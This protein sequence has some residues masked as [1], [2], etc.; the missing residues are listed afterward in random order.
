MDDLHA[1]TVPSGPSSNHATS[2]DTSLTT[3]F[4]LMSQRDRVQAELSA[5]SSVLTSHGVDMET[6]LLDKDGYPRSDIDVAQIRTTRSKIIHLKNDYK[7]LMEKIEKGLH[8]HHANLANQPQAPLNGT[9][10]AGEAQGHSTRPTQNGTTSIEAPFAKVNSIAISS[11]AET[12]GLRVGDKVVK[13]G[14][15]NWTNHEKLSRVAQV[16]Q[17]NEGR[18]IKIRVLRAGEGSSSETVDV[19]LVPRHNWGGR[20]M[21]GCHLM[22]I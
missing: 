19:Q 18:E 12:A 3:L 9:S 16:V 13:F 7:W 14:Y 17:A 6:P 22:P 4:G 10:V 11:P 20:G 5:L 21:L 8:E 2:I 1:P 15:V